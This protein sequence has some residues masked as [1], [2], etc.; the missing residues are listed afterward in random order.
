VVQ[1]CERYNIKRLVHISSCSVYGVAGYGKGHVVTEDSALERWPERR[2][3]YS[4]A[5]LEAEK[6][7]VEGMRTSAVQATC[8]RPGTIYGPGGE[9]FT[10][11]MGFN[12]GT[13]VFAIIGNGEFVLPFV[14]I[15]NLVDAIIACLR[16]EQAAGKIYNVV[17]PQQLT[18]KQYAQKLLRRLYPKSL[19]FY[20][21]YPLLYFTVGVQEIVFRLLKRRPFLTRYRLTAS[22]KRIYYDSSKLSKDLGWHA[23]VSQEQALGKICQH[24]II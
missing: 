4:H 12:L 21:P 10:P 15:D 9:V 20:I 2:G 13:K 5:K 19:H 6:I 14:Y 22:Q 7:V 8:L 16:S 3:P 17:D 1:L 23:P 18:K 24:E 11:I